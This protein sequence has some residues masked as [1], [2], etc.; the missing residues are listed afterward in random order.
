MRDE[1]FS[2]HRKRP[3]AE[4]DRMIGSGPEEEVLEQYASMPR[5]QQEQS[6]GMLGGMKLSYLEMDNLVRRRRGDVAADS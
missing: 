5:A 6:F 4:E 1:Q 3:G 2:L